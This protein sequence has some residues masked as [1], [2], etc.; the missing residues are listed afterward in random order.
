MPKNELDL[1]LQRVAKGSYSEA[2]GVFT[3]TGSLDER[4]LLELI[5]QS[6]QDAHR[7][8]VE[9]GVLKIRPGR[10]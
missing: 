7:V 6:R 2:S 10:A 9:A 8:V 5:E 4:R 3:V 1:H